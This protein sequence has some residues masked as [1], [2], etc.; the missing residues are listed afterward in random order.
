MPCQM[1]S[2]SWKQLKLWKT[3]RKQKWDFGNDWSS[4]CFYKYQNLK[5]WKIQNLQRTG[6]TWKK[7]AEWPS[8]DC[9]Y[10]KVFI[11][12]G[13]IF[14]IFTLLFKKH[15]QMLVIKWSQLAGMTFCPIL[16]GSALHKLYLEIIRE[17]FYPGDVCWDLSFKNTILR[18]TS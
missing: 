13:F 6:S 5:T 3:N 11:L 17:K 2:Q 12:N 7:H 18:A 15:T 14:F 10:L 1:L 4:D 16:L 9:F 8:C